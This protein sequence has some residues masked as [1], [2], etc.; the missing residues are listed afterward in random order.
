MI[1]MGRL[2]TEHMPYNALAKK[3]LSKIRWSVKLWFS[4]IFQEKVSPN[5]DVVLVG[6]SLDLE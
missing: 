1:N 6:F 5:V 4:K 3:E 2:K